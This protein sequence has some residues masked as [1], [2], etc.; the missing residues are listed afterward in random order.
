MKRIA[1]HKNQ[2]NKKTSSRYE[3]NRFFILNESTGPRFSPALAEEIGDR[4]SLI[5]LQME[6]LIAIKGQWREC[7]LDQCDYE[8]PTAPQTNGE[9]EPHFHKWLYMSS[10][11]AAEEFRWM[12][13]STLKRKLR[14]GLVKPGYLMA[15]DTYNVRRNDRTLWYAINF[16]GARTLKSILLSDD[17]QNGESKSDIDQNEPDIDQN[18]L[19]CIDHFDLALHDKHDEY[20]DKT[21]GEPIGPPSGDLEKDAR[22][23]EAYEH[24][25]RRIVCEGLSQAC[26][27]DGQKESLLDGKTK[28]QR[29]TAYKKLRESL[30]HVTDPSELKEMIIGFGLYFTTKR[31][32]TNPTTYFSFPTFA[33]VPQHWPKFEKFCIDHLG[34]TVPQPG[35]EEKLRRIPH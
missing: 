27:F 33:Q 20:I 1:A 25:F 8:P 2:V 12:S 6:F 15:T 5:Y 24:R 16:R 3:E 11:A 7:N 19:S 34:G 14:E 10:R 17:L 18:D 31:A 32:S 13:E 23:A 22:N 28:G 29:S 30:A 9:I 35:D 26:G 4:E 21:E